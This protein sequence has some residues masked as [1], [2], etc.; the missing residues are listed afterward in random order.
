MLC[1]KRDDF[2]Q[3]Q[4]AATSG[5]IVVSAG[6]IQVVFPDPVKPGVFEVPQ[7]VRTAVLAHIESCIGLVDERLAQLDVQA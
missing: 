2:L 3:A 7:I 4:R 1:G 6:G 5:N